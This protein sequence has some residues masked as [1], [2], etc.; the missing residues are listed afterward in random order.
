MKVYK[1]YKY[2]HGKIDVPPSFLLWSI[3]VCRSTTGYA[4]HIIIKG[5]VVKETRC[6]SLNN[7]AK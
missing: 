6:K 7:F 5:I 3:I 4:Y 2:T 1:V